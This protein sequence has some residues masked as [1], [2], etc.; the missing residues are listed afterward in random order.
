MKKGLIRKANKGF[1][2]ESTTIHDHEII[3]LKKGDAGEKLIRTDGQREELMSEQRKRIIP[4]K[5]YSCLSS[6]GG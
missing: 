4:A 3:L 2:F 6:F 5:R 1:S